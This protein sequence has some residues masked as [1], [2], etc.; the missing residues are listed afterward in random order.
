MVF[1]AQPRQ[2]KETLVLKEATAPTSFT[3]PFALTGLTPSLDADG[4]VLFKD[5]DG[6]VRQ[7]LPHGYMEDAHVSAI[8]G[9]GAVS[10]GVT[11][12]LT[13]V[14]GAPALQVSL[15]EAWL[16]D[17]ARVFPV[18]VDPTTT[19]SGASVSTY[20]ESPYNQNF[21]T[22]SDIRAGS[23]DNGGHKAN[24]YLWFGNWGGELSNAY[25]ESAT[26]WL[27][28]THSGGCTNQG[29][30]V[31]PITS[32][33]QYNTI[34]YYPGVS[35]GAAVGWNAF[36]AGD[37][38]GGARWKSVN[39]GVSAREA[40]V[41]LVESWVH[42]GSN[43]G[44]AVTTDVGSVA[45]WKR[46]K[47]VN[48][49]APPYLA[50]TY[51]PVGADYSVGTAVFPT[52]SLAGSAQVTVTNRGNSTWTTDA[53]S[54]VP[55]IYDTSWNLIS[56][57]MPRTALP[58]S[59]APNQSTTVNATIPSMPA[60]NYIICWSMWGPAGEFYTQY[61]VPISAP[62]SVIPSG[63]T[64]PRIYAMSPLTNNTVG[65]T[66]PL[67]SVD[68]DDPDHYPQ[69][70]PGYSFQ[71][72]E[73]GATSPVASSG[74]MAANAWSPPAGALK[75]GK[76][77]AWTASV[78]D[79]QDVTTSAPS[80]FT[81]V[82]DQPLVTSHLGGGS[83]KQVDP[84]VG[85]YTTSA[86]DA[87]VA[88]VGP[89][90]RISR[91]YNSL[92]PRTDTLFGA[93][94]I[95][96][97]DMQALPDQDG[98]GNVVVTLANGRQARFGA[99]ND[100]TFTAPEGQTIVLAARSGGGYTLTDT[101]GTVFTFAQ[102][103][104]AGWRPTAIADRDARSV[105]LAYNPDGTLATITNTTAGRSLHLAW[106]PVAHH[107]ATITTDR[108]TPQDPNSALV[109]TYTY[110]A[111]QL[112]KVCPPTSSTDCTQYAG[113]SG[114][115]SGSHFRT[116]VMDAGPAHY[117]RLD[118]DS[119]GAVRQVD[120]TLIDL[121]ESRNAA[122][123]YTGSAAGPLAGVPTKAAVFNGTTSYVGFPYKPLADKTRATAGVWFKTSSAGVLLSEGS[124]PDG[125]GTYSDLLL[126][127]GTDG[128]L[129]G[130][131]PNGQTTRIVSSSLVNDNKWHFAV[132]TG[133]DSTQSLYLD[134][135]LV[136]TQSGMLSITG[137][138]YYLGAGYTTDQPAHPADQWGHLNGQIGEFALYNHVLGATAVQQQYTAATKAATE[139]SKITLPSGKIQMTAQYSAKQDRV[140]NYTDENDATWTVE[141]PTSKTTDAGG[142]TAAV[143][144]GR[145]S[146]YW[147]LGDADGATAQDLT[148][149]APV[150]PASG[151]YH[152]VT[153]NAAG[154]LASGSTASATFNGTSSFVQLPSQAA[155][156]QGPVSI[157][158][159]F[160]TTAP[161][162]LYSYQSFPLG[163]AASGT[164]NWNPALYI[165]TDGKLYSL[166]WGGQS[167]THTSAAVNDGQ[168]HFAV[169]SAGVDTQSLYLDGAAVGTPVDG[170]LAY[171]GNAYA[172]LGAGTAEGWAAAPT[173]PDGHFKG[174]IA[175][176]FNLPYQLGAPSI[177][178]LY[179]AATTNPGPD[180]TA[181]DLYQAAVVNSR[182]TGYWRLTD[183]G[184]A[185]AA[186]QISV[187]AANGS[188][189]SY[190]NVTLG[191]AGP[192]ASPASKSAGFNGTT[193]VLQLPV[194]DT[195]TRGASFELWFKA[196]GPGVLYGSQDRPLGSQ[197]G[198]LS[199]S[200]TV[201]YIGS[202]NMLYAGLQGSSIGSNTT[203]TDGAW[204]HVVVTT[205]QG[206]QRIA[207]LYLDGVERSGTAYVRW[208][209][210]PYVYVG[211][212]NATAWWHGPTDVEGRLPGAVA[213]VAQYDA[214]LSPETVQ[215][216]FAA[217]TQPRTDGVDLFAAYRATVMASQ[218]RA[219]WR[220]DDVAGA[221]AAGSELSIPLP[222]G[223]YGIN[224][225][226]AG[227]DSHN[228]P[229]GAN[230]DI[231][232]G[233]SSYVQ[234]PSSAA[235]Q[236]GPNSIEL[237]FQTSKPGVLLSYQDFSLSNP[238]SATDMWNPAMYVGTDGK[239]YGR[240]WGA[241]QLVTPGQVTDNKWHQVALTSN[242]NQV[243]L[244]LD[245]KPAAG[246]VAGTLQY[247]GAAYV[248]LGAGTTTGW[249]N[250][251]SSGYFTGEISQVAAYRSEVSA[252]DVAARYSRLA[253]VGETANTKR[254]LTYVEVHEI[255]PHSR[256]YQYDP[257][258]GGRLVSVTD[259]RNHFTAYGYDT[260]GFVNAVT[261]QNGHTTT[262]G[263][264][265]RGN[266][267]STTT[268]EDTTKCS[269]AYASYPAAGAFPDGD[270]RNHLPTSRADGRS[271]GPADSTYATT[272]TYSARGD[273]LSSTTPAT[274]DFPSG[275]TSTAT[276][277]TG[278]EAAP[279]GGTQPA[280]LFASTQDASGQTTRYAYF[281]NGDLESKTAPSGLVTKYT[282]DALGRDT[283]TTQVSDTYPAGVM[284]AVAYD[285]LGR[286]TTRTDPGTVNA[287]TGVTHT[288]KTTRTFDADGNVL[289][290][291]DADTTG[292][293]APRTTMWTYDAYD[294]VE[295]VTTAAGKTTYAYDQY[296]NKTDST[297]PLG[298]HLTYTYSATNQLETTTLTNYTGDPNHPKSAA[299]QI[300]ESRA[301][302]PAGRMATVTDAMGR[303]K[304]YYYNDNNTLAEIDQDNF[305][306]PD[307]TSR[308]VVL[309]Q[310]F[311]DGAG[312]AIRQT[313]GGGR[314]T[315]TAVFDAAGR[316]TSTMLDPGGLERTATFTY[317]AADRP[318]R[319]L[320][321]APG[322]AKPEETLYAYDAAGH[323]TAESITTDTAA[324]AGPAGW[325]KLNDGSGTIAA[326]ATSHQSGT[327]APGVSWSS[328][329][330]GSAAFNGTGGINTAGP[331]LD[332]SKSFT[333]SAWAKLTDTT[334]FNTV[335][336][337]DGPTYS[338]FYLQYNKFAG[339]WV[340]SRPSDSSNNPPDW[341]VAAATAPPQVG[342]W[343]HLTGVFDA[344]TNH[345]KLYVNGVLQSDV[346][347]STPWNATGPFTI[348][349]ATYNGDLFHGGIA[350][351]EAYDR[352]LTA[353]E[354]QA[355]VDHPGLAGVDG[356]L[357]TTHTY[358]QRGLLTSTTDPRGNAIGANAADYTTRYVYDQAGQPTQVIAPTVA[359]ETGGGSPQNVH[360]ITLTGY[361]TFGAVTAVDDPA[362][363]IA[364]FTYDDAGRQ[365]AAAAPAYTP[366]GSTT[367]LTPVTTRE[368]DALGRPTK[369]T[370]PL[371][372][373]ST[374]TYDQFGNPARQT[375]PAV[376]SGTPTTTT[377]Y[378]LVG[379]A[380]A[381]VGPTGARTESTYDDLGRPVTTTQ[382]VRQPTTQALTTSFTYDN[383]GN[384][385]TVKS[386]S[387]AVTTAAYNAAG[388]QVSTTDSLGRTTTAAFDLGGRRTKLT[389]PDGTATTNAY[390][391]AGRL[392][393]AD[394]LD[395]VGALLAATKFGN[396]AAG[397]LTSRTDSSGATSR[398]EY[399]AT[400]NRTRQI[401]PVTATG[402]ITTTF[403]YDA[404][405]RRTRYT[406][407][408][409][410]P[411]YYGYNTLGLP[412]YTTVPATTGFTAVGDRTTTIGYDAA[413]RSVKSTR[414]GGVT[415]SS[416]YDALGRLTSQSGTGAQ[417]STPT[418]T[419]DYDLAGRTTSAGTPS[420]TNT[421][422]YDDRALLLTA[423]GPGGNAT[424]GYTADGDLATRTDKAGTATFTWDAAGQLK[425][426]NEPQTGTT[427][428]Y[429]YN[430]T[431]DVTSVA[432]GTGSTRTLTYDARH[433][434]AS[435]TLKAPGGTV[436]AQT[437]YTRDS[438]GRI[439]TQTTGGL[440]GSG[441]QT[442]TYDQAGRLATWNDGTTQTGY[443]Y[444]NAGNRTTVT[445]PAATITAVYNARNQLTA[446]GGTSYTYD[447]RGTQTSRTSAGVTRTSAF[448]AYDQLTSAGTSSYTYDAL[449]RMATGPGGRTFTYAGA[450]TQ[451]VSDGTETYSRGPS[452]NF[453]ALGNGQGSALA[454]TNA[455]GDLLATFNANGS[456]LAGSTA[457]DPYGQ[458]RVTTGNASSL[459]Y[460][461]GWT[462]TST[463]QVNM[464]ARWYDPATAAFT[465]ADTIAQEPT[466][467]VNGNP[468][469]YAND[470]PLANADPTGHFSLSCGPMMGKRKNP[471][472]GPRSGSP[473]N[474]GR[475]TPH[476]NPGNP[477][478]PPG[479]GDPVRVPVPNLSPARERY[480]L[481][482]RG[483]AIPN[484][485]PGRVSNSQLAED[486]L[487]DYLKNRFGH[488][489][490]EDAA[491]AGLTLVAPEIRIPQAARG[492]W[493]GL[494]GLGFAS[495]F[496]CDETVDRSHT[497]NGDGH[498]TDHGSTGPD[499]GAV[500][501]S[502]TAQTED[503][504][505]YENA[506]GVEDDNGFGIPNE[507]L[508][509]Y[510]R[511][512]QNCLQRAGD[513]YDYKPLDAYGRATGAQ[514]CL[515]DGELEKGTAPSSDPTGYGPAQDLADQEGLDE[516]AINACHLIAS[517]LGG[518]GIQRNLATCP[519]QT[520]AYVRGDG[521]ISENMRFYEA[522]V[523]AAVKAK[524]I[525][526]YRV[527]PK[528]AN[529]DPTKN[530]VPV[531]F[532]MMALG[533][534]AQGNVGFTLSVVVPNS[535]YSPK[536]KSWINLGFAVNK[537]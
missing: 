513:R 59:V 219:Y 510:N 117:W 365:I 400:G 182:P 246:P 451:L 286:I 181:A 193:S 172:Y 169:L 411:T 268:C 518:R 436:Q 329:H 15:D 480:M 455:H 218:P 461:G 204:H 112:A 116:M 449:G 438:N 380:L 1:E 503:L 496:S 530:P 514:A 347:D 271:S 155:P 481:G 184:G 468:Y 355:L 441:T 427:L 536:R 269:T 341:P 185:V 273:V 50:V 282:Y 13:T 69:A 6:V 34:K 501:G 239:L 110:N 105:T 79:G 208:E 220:L 333:V 529:G 253:P 45:A 243:T 393:E 381:V 278:T 294:R 81:P 370:D 525:V 150:R 452:G 414:P 57:T 23:W 32:D 27:Y 367:P 359:A 353:A 394:E 158:L 283:T 527:T 442:Y 350:D 111:D 251:P 431:G 216:H 35:I 100:G 407:G 456:G 532:E 336:A 292:G 187:T 198:S 326:D 284:V 61:G 4:N 31:S 139:L 266:T 351:V 498:L 437:T 73:V 138:Y 307:G 384:Q 96:A 378:D 349:K 82:I 179:A 488:D 417:A 62:C 70:S 502:G 14:D 196:T 161:G 453:L 287:V 371:G 55:W 165:G 156:T 180:T 115:S 120:E 47:S 213:E 332:S 201:L 517:T 131:L 87:D 507:L 324:P 491:L 298:N 382:V 511:N 398:W 297:D 389:M 223:S 288:P 130:H 7:T 209:D 317:D 402:S 279:G 97:Y 424:L 410:N 433:Q 151:T 289:T 357:T 460:Q 447:A 22:G 215:A 306:N 274:P 98:T 78:G 343:T 508:Q 376:A 312:H 30:T 222:G 173:D 361:D 19:T 149:H 493:G 533:T 310:D 483:W 522:Q 445:T 18:K 486:A 90:L 101:S 335:V 129:Y 408:N 470:D 423:A 103:N 188:S 250:A 388:E 311:Y 76:K 387:G 145:P 228:G 404:A 528:Y 248:Y 344:S 236:Q 476:G 28:N 39:L 323:T 434:L 25:I 20:V 454:Y 136:G 515:V 331:A 144:S 285:K 390:D 194:S 403:G 221:T 309:E 249:A 339:T 422:T 415:V 302:D 405:G 212:G 465:S 137:A 16:H 40:G 471:P 241:P 338:G 214:V 42:G 186:E 495:L 89:A 233:T 8:S 385:L 368:F 308:S 51:S 534:D 114:E 330:G 205:G 300:L 107:V 363:N 88:V 535:I 146:G 499:G 99:N 506:P 168:W 48:S 207:S 512:G 432:Y 537:Y 195:P 435:D 263:H 327:L 258:H 500:D 262:I 191:G 320:R 175:E 68:G 466:P 135:A 472:P 519:R 260:G 160:K 12:S 275:R 490:W 450:S 92:D 80:Y 412:E 44:L 473:G 270:V 342:V 122:P 43:L 276:Y 83:D 464:A 477:S 462:D 463:G 356:R 157:G 379:E 153:S 448:D 126:Y 24:A 322:T 482:E 409:G 321:T 41:Q 53:F 443:G 203:V 124:P 60:G 504:P 440:A 37:T 140:A 291:T 176:T 526:D 75:W 474:F 71:I 240:F 265:D 244:Y 77:Y 420:G 428:T 419:F 369:V 119:Q 340:F 154:P 10:T 521:R 497:D 406:D 113:T 66:T 86:V 33:W 104:G 134:G 106:D 133:V 315:T 418:R 261:D 152:D 127:V 505:I 426:A 439:T 3:Y 234:L 38:C 430:Q 247:N 238:H 118:A 364:S 375:A 257:K 58:G 108:A 280:G 232:N 225:N 174:Q 305:R 46:F 255:S 295:S 148:W 290:Q 65:S 210:R 54:V 29:V 235:P 162:V 313:T 293:D 171:N 64:K 377:T 164:R 316:T 281:A 264:D 230:A 159:W 17:P 272:F 9:E 123:I 444:D 524:Q 143:L 492:L 63:N 36:Y 211:A 183:A 446:A 200:G 531:S 304:H 56:N 373:V 245:G 516:K 457:Y 478:D 21:S 429:G 391:T 352:A 328:E 142:Y 217:A 337:Q 392:I 252:A 95:T 242:G 190:Q 128:K 325:W 93:G 26:L 458:K 72:T 189:G 74:W 469:A 166:L 2:V 479:T 132:L 303:T 509:E 401:E 413:G 366:P 177:A 346:V 319:V 348:G 397:L 354:V 52:S 226:L 520:N 396:D 267:V 229:G 314:T 170:K 49:D 231:F 256:M 178:S 197:A 147:P 277:T 494:K 202:D 5:A 227:T 475:R 84:L 416:V 484:P 224:N 395:S 121:D 199:G 399:N 259:E 94:W 345:M 192:I 523:A 167:Q 125:S 109:W 163:G 386:P 141:P 296:G 237:W 11:Y 362:G 487:R 299:A 383:A 301:Y 85:N 372:G 206:S 360:P 102:Q 91:T 425:T 489:S 318:T 334:S 67:L 467:S 358:D 254:A 459:G 485:L 421:Y 374:S